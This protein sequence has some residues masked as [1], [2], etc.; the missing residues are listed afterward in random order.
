MKGNRDTGIPV[1]SA[2]RPGL[3]REFP[4]VAGAALV[5]GGVRAVSERIV[6][7]ARM[8]GQRI[9]DLERALGIAWEHS[10]QGVVLPHASLVTLVNWVYI[11]GHWPVILATAVWL[12]RTQRPAYVRLRN[13]MFLSGVVGFAFF[14]SFRRRPPL[15]QQ[16]RRAPARVPRVGAG[17]RG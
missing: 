16:R 1:L 12:Y 3:V 15:R 10:A 4:L 8:N 6:A 2:A 7:E 17:R 13:A 11:W 5:Y 9:L 14:R